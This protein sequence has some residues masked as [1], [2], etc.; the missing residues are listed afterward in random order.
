MKQANLSKPKDP[1]KLAPITPEREEEA[2]KQLIKDKQNNMKKVFWVLAIIL[3]ANLIVAGTKVIL[4]FV[5]KSTS[6]TADGFH[7]VADSFSNV[8]GMVA[9]Y[10]AMQPD[11]KEH[12][13]GHTKIETLTGAGIGLVL[14]YLGIRV[15]L[16]AIEKF[17]N[18][19]MPQ[20]SAVSLIMIVVT[21]GINIFVARYERKK[22]EELDSPILISDSAHTKSDVFISIG[23][24][25]GLIVMKL[26][27]PSWL[28]PLIS[29]VV[30]GFIFH[31]AWEV[32]EQNA[33]VLIDGTV[34]D[35]DFIERKVM[36]FKNVKGVHRIRSRG[37]LNRP[38][39]DMHVMVDPNLTVADIHKLEHQIEDYFR[40]LL[41]APAGVM[42]HFEPCF[43][44]LGGECLD[45]GEKEA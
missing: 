38:F 27:L 13:Y 24:L 21:I 29:L 41:D 34:I 4:G 40:R 33:N 9:L 2:M 26:G 22:G 15:V 31:A 35:E 11:D 8:V 1:E 14:V 10:F 32:F 17:K 3:V 16:E 30:A 18:P 5:I 36:K 19:V 42:I 20:Y 39:I 6:L 7:S 23:V 43:E 25:A 37:T 45:D 28:D 12:P 44:V